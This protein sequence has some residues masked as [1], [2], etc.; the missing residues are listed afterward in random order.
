MTIPEDIMAAAEKACLR[1]TTAQDRIN[2]VAK[3]ILAE[4]QRCAD[5]AKSVWKDAQRQGHFD[6]V[7]AISQIRSRIDTGAAA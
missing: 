1:P 6:I 3:A 2:N 4:R 7:K 5:V